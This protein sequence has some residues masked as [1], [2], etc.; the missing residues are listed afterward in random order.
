MKFYKSNFKTQF[1]L[2]GTFYEKIGMWLLCLILTRFLRYMYNMTILML[3]SVR[4]HT[5]GGESVNSVGLDC[6]GSMRRLDTAPSVDN[7]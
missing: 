7:P 5:V 2:N 4:C 6:H 3:V 1:F